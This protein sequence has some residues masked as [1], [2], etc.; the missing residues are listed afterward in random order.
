MQRCNRIL[1]FKNATPDCHAVNPTP[2][3]LTN[4]FSVDATI[5]V[6][7][8]GPL[9]AKDELSFNCPPIRSD[10]DWQRIRDK[11]TGDHAQPLVDP[12]PDE[13]RQTGDDQHALVFPASRYE[14]QDEY[15]D[16]GDHHHQLNQ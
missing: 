11:T 7:Q 16:D 10:A 2:N 3:K 8:G 12:G 13:H 6:L 1:F 4:V 9:D 15:G 5:Q 14:Q